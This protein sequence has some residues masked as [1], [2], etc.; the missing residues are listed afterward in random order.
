MTMIKTIYESA[1]DDENVKDYDF[2]SDIVMAD[3]KDY[4]HYEYALRF[5]IFYET[6]SKAPFHE[7]KETVAEFA[8]AISDEIEDI[9][10]YTPCINDMSQPQFNGWMLV[11][12]EQYKLPKA[13]ELV[14][15]VNLDGGE[16]GATLYDLMFCGD[17]YRIS[18]F[19]KFNISDSIKNNRK[20]TIQ[21]IIYMIDRIWMTL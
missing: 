21:H 17:G 8:N 18:V 7:S 1:F 15:G 20:F 19:F 16:Y 14:D 11:K 10:K 5:D 9:C 6:T 12:D 4:D 3:S 2:G 13:P